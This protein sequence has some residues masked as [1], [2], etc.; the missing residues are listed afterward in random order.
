MR[1]SELVRPVLAELESRNQGTPS[2]LR[3]GAF[4]AAFER[5]PEGEPWVQ[6][7]TGVLNLF[8]QR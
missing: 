6:V 5:P 1:I 8:Y 7:K 2:S 4:C 3:G